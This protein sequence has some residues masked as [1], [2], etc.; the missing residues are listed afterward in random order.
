[1]IVL[2]LPVGATR[3]MRAF[4]VR[5]YD[6]IRAMMS[7]LIR[8]HTRSCG[9]RSRPRKFQ[10]GACAL[11]RGEHGAQ[12]VVLDQA[13][14]MAGVD[15]ALADLVIVELAARDQLKQPESR[16]VKRGVARARQ[17]RG[18]APISRIERGPAIGIRRKSPSAA[19]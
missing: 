4:A 8:A 7:A 10:A 13:I 1:M 17:R 14:A 15:Q 3:I 5:A 11:N 9:T 6:Q 19:F 12:P 2:P 16:A 18:E